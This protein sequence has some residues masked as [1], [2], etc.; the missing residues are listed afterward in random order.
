MVG[1][2][3]IGSPAGRA[4][5]GQRHRRAREPGELLALLGGQVGL[6][7]QQVQRL[8]AVARADAVGVGGEPDRGRCW[9]AECGAGGGVGGGV[10]HFGGAPSWRWVFAGV[11]GGQGVL[12]GVDGQLDGAWACDREY[13]PGADRA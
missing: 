11:P 9:P 1:T 7:L 3:G 4:G 10:Q 12:V 6:V 13:D 8:P 5:G 2:V